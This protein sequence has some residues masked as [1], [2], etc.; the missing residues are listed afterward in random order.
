M[1]SFT[2]SKKTV[3]LIRNELYSFSNRSLVNVIQFKIKKLKNGLRPFLHGNSQ[4]DNH[5]KMSLRMVLSAANWS[6]RS[7]LAQLLRSTK[8]VPHSN[9]WKISK[10][11]KKHW[12]PTVSQTLMFSKQSTCSKRRTSH[13][14]PTHSSLL[15]APYGRIQTGMDQN[16]DQNQLIWTNVNSQKNNWKLAK[17]SLACKPVKTKVNIIDS[18]FSFQFIQFIILKSPWMTWRK[19]IHMQCTNWLFLFLQSRCHP[20]RSK[21]RCRPKN[22]FGQVSSNNHQPHF[23][24]STIEQREKN[25]IPK[26]NNPSIFKH[27]LSKRLFFLLLC[28]RI[29]IYI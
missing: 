18:Y 19:D 13:K 6:T 5:T 7:N 9:W 14:L 27:I 16:W 11:S 17:Q 20:S 3:W 24:Y 4:L 12:K 28:T 23:V 26:L 29:Y 25:N 15:A 8:V 10:T 21:Y 22:P 2:K 1:N